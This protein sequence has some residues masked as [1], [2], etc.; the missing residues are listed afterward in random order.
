[1]RGCHL[2]KHWSLT[3]TTV[4]LNSAEAELGG[5]CKGTSISMG[6][7]SVARD[8]GLEWTIVVLTDATAAIG[9]CK[10]RGLGKIHDTLQQ[11]TSGSTT[12][13]GAESSNG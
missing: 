6:L 12:S 9:V 1:M 7:R 5:I 4:A 11:P 3:Q 8:L 2:V 10:R 13:S